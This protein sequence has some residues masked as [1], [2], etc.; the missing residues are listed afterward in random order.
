M[1][2]KLSVR[3]RNILYALITIVCIVLIYIILVEPLFMR[4]ND[5]NDKIGIQ[6]A[7]LKKSLSLIKDKNNIEAEYDSYA[8][9]LKKRHNDEQEMT[10]VLDEI[11]KTARRSNLKITSMR[12]KPQ[13]Q[14]Q[15]Y[16]RFEVEIETESDM[17]SLMR[18][19]YDIKNSPQLIKIDRLNFNTRGSH[20]AVLIRAVMLI[21][22]IAL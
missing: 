15:H 9:R 8:E 21:S 2:K 3:E 17:D 13:R 14:S 12:P 22:K 4:W 16:T 5:V 19:I 6:K 7:R 11:E 18:F 1:L 20:Q 10:L